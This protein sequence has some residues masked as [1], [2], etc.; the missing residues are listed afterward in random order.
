VRKIS[1]LLIV[2]VLCGTATSCSSNGKTDNVDIDY[3]VSEKYKEEEIE[4]AARLVLEDF[5]RFN[6]CELIKLK[7]SEEDSLDLATQDSDEI[8]VFVADFITGESPAA[9]LMSNY[10]YSW[11]W[12]LEREDLKNEW[13]IT[14]YGDGL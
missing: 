9:G 11:K 13:E 14:D 6:N 8:I 4:A 7:Y 12:I 1:L 10:E 2:L 5:K 3:G